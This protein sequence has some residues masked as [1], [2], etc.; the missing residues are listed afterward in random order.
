MTI[1]V[2]RVLVLF[3]VGLMSAVALFGCDLVKN[4][5]GEGAKVDEMS[6]L[7]LPVSLRAGSP[8]PGNAHVVQLAPNYVTVNGERVLEFEGGEFPAAEVSGDSAPKL[9]AALSSP[10]KSAVALEVH[11]N[12]PFINLLRVLGSAQA[13]GIRSAAFKVRKPGGTADTGWM[14]LNG[15]KVMA[16]TDDE[17]KF[18]TV[19]PRSWDDFVAVWEHV[20]MGCMSGRG[21]SC[22]E[23]KVKVATG[24]NVQTTLFSAGDGVNL[25]FERMGGPSIEE[26]TEQ[27]EALPAEERAEVLKGMPPE[28][29]EGYMALPFAESAGFQFRS[30]EAV[31]TDSPVTKAMAP[32]CGKTACAALMKARKVTLSVRVLQ[33]IGAAFPDGTPAPTLAFMVTEQ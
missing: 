17:V 6:V 29:I 26:L 28:V 16:D 7:A 22:V 3:T 23:K 31:I 13:A 15:F 33:L 1:T 11:S 27:L 14:E 24:G 19:A 25:K 30:R 5:K 8:E 2:H 9:K 32:F 18:D 12:A 21:T 4:G 10:A 20:H